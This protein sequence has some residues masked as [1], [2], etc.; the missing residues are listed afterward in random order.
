MGEEYQKS[1]EELGIELLEEIREL[2]SHL[3]SIA[4]S[5]SDINTDGI[6]VEVE[7]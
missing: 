3:S 2:N 7:E 6:M 4:S 1:L 5:L